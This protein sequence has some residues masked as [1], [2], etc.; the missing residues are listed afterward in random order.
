VAPAPLRIY[1]ESAEKPDKKSKRADLLL[2]TSCRFRGN[3]KFLYLGNPQNQLQ[4][5]DFCREFTP[6][7]ATSLAWCATSLR[8]WIVLPRELFTPGNAALYV[9]RSNGPGAGASRSTL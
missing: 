5:D 2:S 6:S 3:G 8:K 1:A 4:P 9:Q 7:V